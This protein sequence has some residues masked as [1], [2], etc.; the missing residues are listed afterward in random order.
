MSAQFVEMSLFKFKGGQLRTMQD[1]RNG[2]ARFAFQ[3]RKDEQE[4]VGQNQILFVM[5]NQSH[6]IEFALFKAQTK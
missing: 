4:K 1:L 2:A 6:G 3:V 5:Q